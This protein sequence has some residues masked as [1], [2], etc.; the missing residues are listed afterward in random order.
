MYDGSYGLSYILAVIGAFVL[1]VSMKHFMCKSLGKIV[2]FYS[3]GT[4][5]ILGTHS[6]FFPYLVGIL[7]RYI[8]INNISV[9]I[10]LVLFFVVI[11]PVIK[12]CSSYCP[13]VLGK[14]PQN[15]K[16]YFYSIIN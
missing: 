5:M 3:I 15:S 14:L 1:F 12:S 16:S 9:V 7:N 10:C 2:E 4:F 8:H 11:F 13:I 6:I